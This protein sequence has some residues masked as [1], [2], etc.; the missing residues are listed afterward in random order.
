M[1]N[2][3]YLDGG[4]GEVL[5][6]CR[7]YLRATQTLRADLSRSWIAP[8]AE[9]LDAPMPL[10]VATVEA[11]VLN[12]RNQ[13]REL[14]MFAAPRVIS[15]AEDL[16]EAIRAAADA[17]FELH[18]RS[19]GNGARLCDLDGEAF[20]HHSGRV[21]SALEEFSRAVGR[22]TVSAGGPDRDKMTRIARAIPPDASWMKF[23]LSRKPLHRVPA[24]VAAGL[25]DAQEALQRDIIDFTDPGLAR[26]HQ[27]LVDVLGRL[28]D[29]FG[30]TFPPEDSD[31]LSY[32]EVP[33]EWKRADPTRYYETLQALS[34]AREDVLSAYK[35]LMN[36][37]SSH[38]R[39]RPWSQC[40]ALGRRD[41][42]QPPQ[43]T[44]YPRGSFLDRRRCRRVGAGR[45]QLGLV[46]GGT[47]RAECTPASQ[48]D[49]RAAC[50]AL[51][52]PAGMVGP[53][54]HACARSGHKT[55]TLL[56]T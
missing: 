11:G 26:L 9:S 14:Q 6:V 48:P 51:S 34:H 47:R 17:Q 1:A 45:R 55:L 53:H 42:D 29:E 37:M 24:W 18:V 3:N 44:A 50:R 22:Q 46:R 4:R 41:A 5:E 2:F 49:V 10:A 33:P 36:A 56:S 21:D 27:D 28:A 30:G 20:T 15:A 32:T 54:G 40:V 16:Y 8:P 7:S 12:L 13:L 23:L 35:K 38:Q 52:D 19:P 43:P 39:E 25:D 31:T